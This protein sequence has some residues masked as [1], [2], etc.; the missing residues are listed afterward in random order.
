MAA[1]FTN[2]VMDRYIEESNGKDDAG[3]KDDKLETPAPPK[4]TDDTFDEWFEGVC[5][6]L[7]RHKGR[8]GVPLRYVI[9]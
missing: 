6:N 7:R 8:S 3:D 9:R 5:N 1:D 2:A 4:R